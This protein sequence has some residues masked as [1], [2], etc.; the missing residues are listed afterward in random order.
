[1]DRTVYRYV[2]PPEVQLPEVEATLALAILAAEALHGT[3]TMLL[4][5]GHYLDVESRTCVVDATA[6]VGRD[7]NCLFTGFLIGEFGEGAFTVERVAEAP[8]RQEAAR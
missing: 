6:P 3:A 7:L 8:A 5:A 2:F 4:D 1:M